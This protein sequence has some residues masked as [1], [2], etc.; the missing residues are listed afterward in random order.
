M[1]GLRDARRK[2]A[3]TKPPQAAEADVQNSG[4]ELDDPWHTTMVTVIY[5][6]YLGY[7]S[8]RKASNDLVEYQPARAER[9]MVILLTEL[10]CFSFLRN[11]FK[12]EDLRW[13]RLQLREAEYKQQ[14]LD[15]YDQVIAALHGQNATDWLQ[16]EKTIPALESRYHEALGEELAAASKARQ[17]ARTQA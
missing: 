9:L 8:A 3:K 1:K 7:E 4:T 2:L 16:A 10:K 14:V 6:L 5:L 11:H 15:V 13:R 17:G 12:P